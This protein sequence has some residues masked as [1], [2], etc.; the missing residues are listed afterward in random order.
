MSKRS[1]RTKYT[2][3]EKSMM[4]SILDE[5][6]IAADVVDIDKDQEEDDE[7]PSVRGSEAKML[8]EAELSVAESKNSRTRLLKKGA[9]NSQGD[10][11]DIYT[12][13]S[14]GFARKDAR[15]EPVVKLK[16]NASKGRGLIKGLGGGQPGQ[17]NKIDFVHSDDESARPPRQAEDENYSRMFAR[18]ERGNTNLGRYTDKEYVNPNTSLKHANIPGEHLDYDRHGTPIN[19]HSDTFAGASLRVPDL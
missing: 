3:E 7:E 8:P 12:N 10:G 9:G 11:S 15:S 2:A 16:T 17:F 13:S 18:G 6:G 5:H 1:T 14:R 4:N 19:G